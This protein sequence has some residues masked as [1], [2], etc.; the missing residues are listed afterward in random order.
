M[1]KPSEK[2]IKALFARSGNICAFPGCQIPII[3]DGDIV[4]GEI[5]HICA[6]EKGGSRYDLDQ[7]E[8][9]QHSLD[10]LILL[11]GNHHKVIDS[12]T[13]NYTVESLKYIRANHE[14]YCGHSEGHDDTEKARI[15]LVEYGKIHIDNNHGNIAINS[16]DVIQGKTI[17][18]R[19]QKKNQV[20]SAPKGTIGSDQNLS[21][22]V[23]YLIS[24]YNKFAGDDKTRKT[25]FSYGAIAKNIE[26]NFGSTWKLLPKEKAPE[27]F[28]YLQNRIL[29]TRL[30]RIN[31]GK[32]NKSFS[33]FEEYSKK[34]DLL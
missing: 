33:S 24:R 18:I 8:I 4:I 16:S 25:K 32:N 20:I 23:Q 12:D 2:T 3:D 6:K 27:V 19:T 34:I 26:S 15:L 13:K 5:C 17:N 21:R 14:K 7:T 31:T 30:G 28:L 10:N 11:C 1:K 29:K 9:E 22:Y